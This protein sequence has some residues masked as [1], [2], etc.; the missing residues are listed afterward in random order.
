MS[1]L[2]LPVMSSDPGA[3]R[4]ES[5]GAVPEWE[6]ERI[7]SDLRKR[8]TGDVRFS[9][10]ERMLF[11]TDASIYQVEPLGVV[12]PRTVREVQE[13]VGYC[14]AHD[15][16]VLPRGGGTSLAG[17]AVNRAIV[18]DF[19]RYCNRILD[20][21]T[22]NRTATVESGVVLAHLNQSL[23]KHNLMF[24]PDV[25]TAAQANIGGMIGNNSAGAHSILYGRTV[26]HVLALDAVLPDGSEVSLSEGASLVDDRVA[27]L[28]R[29]IAQIV[30][31]LAGVIE[32]RYPKILRHVDGYN[33]DLMLHQ[34]CESSERHEK[35]NLAH[36]LCGSEGTLAVTT[37][38]TLQLVDLPKQKALAVVAFASVDEAL[39]FVQAVLRTKP[40]AVELLDDVVLG[41]AKRNAECRR[42]VQMMPRNA[43]GSVCALLYVE[44]FAAENDELRSKMR[45]L[46]NLAGNRPMKL[47]TT[48]PE[49]VM[50]WSLRAAGEPL[51]HGLPGNRKPLTFV[52]DVAVNPADLP[53][54]IEEFRALL[55]EH[56]TTAAYYA[57][58]SVG[59]LHVRPMIDLRDEHDR[60]RM[61]RIAE[62]VTELAMRYGGALSGEHGDGR[63]RSHL[64]ERFYGSEICDGFRRIKAVFDPRNRMNPGIIVDPKPDS[65]MRHLR[66]RPNEHFVAQPRDQKTY[67]RY[68]TEHGFGQA[69]ELCNG[70]GVCRKTSGGAMCPSYRAT[71]DERHATRGRGNAL[72]LAITGQLSRDGNTPAWNDLETHRTLDLCL[73]CK[74]CKAECPSNVDI[75]KLKA[76][77]LAHAWDERGRPPLATRFF[78]NVRAINKLGSHMAPLANAMMRFAPARAIVNRVLGIDPRRSLPRFERSLYRWNAQRGAMRNTQPAQTVI[79]LPDCFTVYSEPRIG[80][81]AIETLEHLGYRVV[82]PRNVGC[83]GRSLISVGMLPDA[84][85]TCAAVARALIAHIEQEDAVAV[86]GCEPS[87]ISAIV[88]DW[89]DLDMNVDR[90]KL[91][92][93]KERTIAVEE[94]VAQQL[95]LQ[96]KVRKPAAETAVRSD[97]RVLFH[98]HCHQKALWSDAGTERLLHEVLGERIT[99]LDAGCCGMAGS[100]GYGS[101]HYDVSQ[102]IGE[103][104]LFPALRSDPSA[105]ILA[106]GTSCRH[107]IRD[108][109]CRDALHPVDL[110]REMVCAPAVA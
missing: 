22:S 25:A 46:E 85:Q 105:T 29:Q 11:A 68:E 101:A 56:G 63:L 103:L 93:L 54:F 60:E 16:P 70:A 84:R 102:Q 18:I 45:E 106:P 47:F 79:L 108:A 35:V 7:A 90:R 58:A 104:V 80:V 34:L 98:G 99:V 24:G 33:L 40:A 20:I 43:D 73:S 76:E 74:A 6:R 32:K 23:Q 75:A 91:A 72:R 10:H 19:S 8:T 4:R 5:G 26:E 27:E 82:L 87:C 64:L 3:V 36:L 95:L 86:V 100:F 53:S 41:L 48:G 14:A 77:Y 49:M 50:A 67:F 28:T 44:Y 81:A 9:R 39:A 42:Y 30:L 15:L 92:M 37:R 21:D 96:G 51:L 66:V 97:D 71:L 69:I 65:M 55:T 59:C 94:F 1:E 83:C 52:E 38:A 78:G 57:H 110:I 107:Q 31:P 61:Q 2:R 12:A 88:D 62:Q 89:Q 109:L 13:I 17:Q